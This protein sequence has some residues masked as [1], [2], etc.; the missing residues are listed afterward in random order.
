MDLIGIAGPSCS[1]KTALAR[2]VAKRLNAPILPIDAYYRD[3]AHLPFEQRARTNFDVPEAIDHELLSEHLHTLVAGGDVNIPIYDFSRHCRAPGT[4][5]LRASSFGVVEG[6]WTL[7]WEEVRNALTT[8]VYMATKDPVCLERRLRR[9]V[10]ERGRTPESISEQ[11]AATVRPMAALFVV[12][13]R[14]YADLVLSGVDPLETLTAR[15][16]EHALAA[17]RRPSGLG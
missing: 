4:T 16:V 15:V 9:D 17:A 13:T 12:P 7:Y 11:Y 3:L 1:G 14:E 6:L 5:R 2:A 8:R 10:R